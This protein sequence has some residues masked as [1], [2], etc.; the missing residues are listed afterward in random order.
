M[1]SRRASLPIAGKLPYKETLTV[2]HE[3]AKPETETY[4]V[5]DSEI[6]TDLARPYQT[7]V[8]RMWRRKPSARSIFSSSCRERRTISSISSG[9]IWDCDLVCGGRKN[10]C[11]QII[12]ARTYAM[13]G[14]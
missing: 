1:I 10:A 3:I 11:S 2:C 14:P 12:V 13:G 5:P 6:V 8:I 4:F 7:S 9:S